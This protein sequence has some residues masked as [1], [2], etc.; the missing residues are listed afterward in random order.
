MDWLINTKNNKVYVCGLDGDYKRKKF[1]S[2]LDIIPLCDDVIK[3]KAICQEC[4]KA[5]AIFTHRL[6]NEEEQMVIGND[7][8]TSLCRK[9]YN[10]LN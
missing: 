1:G 6:S 4:K 2:I 9:C 8:Y 3:L 7:K 10:L 5:E